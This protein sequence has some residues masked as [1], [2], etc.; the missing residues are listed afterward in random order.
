MK[1]LK[2]S[3][4]IALLC[5]LFLKI[6]LYSADR[7]DENN[8][9][10]GGVWLGLGIGSCHYGLSFCGTANY[11]FG[12]SLFTFRYL[13][14]DELQFGS[15]GGGNVSEPARSLREYGILYGSYMKS[16]ISRSSISVGLS[17]IEAVD[18]GKLID[19]YQYKKKE[20]KAISIPIEMNLQLELD[21]VG[22]GF[23]V[24]A[25]INKQRV[26]VG[27]LLKFLLGNFGS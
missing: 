8:S 16:R 12:K 6:S 10:S 3:V 2:L 18:R 14:A 4:I 15:I 19:D 20:L 7:S 24:F 1:R 27:F 26:N 17:Y 13:K 23:T 9:D 5:C 11:C 21:P 22:L 25:N